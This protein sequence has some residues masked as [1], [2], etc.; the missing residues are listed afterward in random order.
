MR[1][2]L[3]IF[4]LSLIFTLPL[5]FTSC[6][7]E[8]IIEESPRTT[9]PE[10]QELVKA[11]LYGQVIDEQGT[12]IEG[13]VV[14]YRT[15]LTPD[16]VVT[17][18]EG[19]FLIND[20]DN[21]GRAAY[22]SIQS[23]GKFEAFRK[24]SLVSQRTNYTEI[25]MMDRD[26]VGSVSATDGGTITQSD[27]ARV[28]LPAGGIVDASGSTYSGDVEVAMAWIDPSAED[29][30]GALL[31]I[32][33]GQTATLSFPIP[34]SMLPQAEDVIPLWS[35][36]ENAGIWKQEG[37]AY[38]EGDNYVGD[39]SHFS[40]W[41][42]DFMTDPIE[43]TGLVKLEVV[44]N[45]G[46]KSNVGGSF[47]QV[48]VCSELIGRKGG[49]LCEDGS[50]RF[51][52]FPKD[53]QFKLKVTDQCGVTIYEETYGP[54]SN[55]EDLGEIVVEE[56]ATTAIQIT[57]NAVTCDG[58]AVTDGYVLV[59][60]GT[61]ENRFPLNED[62]TFS[63]GYSACESVDV[64]VRII[65][66]NTIET[67]MDIVVGANE[68]ITE[69]TDIEVCLNLDQFIAVNIGDSENY[70]FENV[71][72]FCGDSFVNPDSTVN[73]YTIGTLPEQ[74]EERTIFTLALDMAI[75]DYLDPNFDLNNVQVS[76]AV[77]LR[78]Q[79]EPIACAVDEGVNIIVSFSRFIPEAGDYIQGSF[80]GTLECFETGMAGGLSTTAV[81]GT[82]RIPIV[83][84][85]LLCI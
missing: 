64:I 62:G 85:K 45:D 70:L 81:N 27:G 78:D 5:L 46:K 13:A 12:P 35:Y 51:Y 58:N 7:D 56:T 29:L 69:L 77:F 67:S 76:E 39:V 34:V 22:V 20:V 73:R 72:L 16:Q 36:D 40:S 4:T 65:D 66:L 80:S 38:R 63:I 57:G 55:D 25:M 48:Y 50:F 6:A 15:G 74:D 21:K 52:N 31:N 82:F 47:L 71:F 18:E 41:N 42:V 2:R 14:T 61:L 3:S 54:Y 33:E 68:S 44:D 84:D 10:S 17:D 30:A 59:S 11:T 8:G 83:E 43:I 37:E 60:Q 53:E 79:T 19:Y 1:Q 49:W 32:A 26:I 28:T 24:F 9:I 23:P 75:D